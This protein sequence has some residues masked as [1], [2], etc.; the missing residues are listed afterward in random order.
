M[1]LLRFVVLSIAVSIVVPGLSGLP[2]VHGQTT[3]GSILG[4]VTD[5]SGAAVPGA[6]V[7]VVNDSNGAERETVAGPAGGFRI[8]VLQPSTYSVTVVA[9]GFSPVTRRGVVLP[10]QGEVKVDFVLQV[11]GAAEQILVNAD[12]PLIRPTENALR[13][14]VNNRSIEALPLLTR[15][16]MDLAVLAPGVTLDQSSLFN[17][18]ATDSISFF[19]LEESHKTLWLEGVDFGDEVTT[20]GT[21]TSSASRSPLPLDAIQEFDVMT[22]GYSPEFGRSQGGAVN[23]VLKSGGSELHGSVYSFFQDDAFNRTPWTISSGV[24]VKSTSE[25]SLERRSYGGTIGGPLSFLPSPAFYFFALDRFTDE[26]SVLITIPTDVE[27]FVEGLGLGY[28]TDTLVPLTRDRIVGVGKLTFDLARDHRLDLTYL[29]SDDDDLNKGVGNSTNVGGI[30]AADFGFDERDSS[31]FASANLTSV[32]G[33]RT[34]NEFRANRSIQRLIRTIPEGSGILPTL[35]FP[36]VVFGTNGID[37]FPSARVQKN[38]ILAN[39]TSYQWDNHTLRWGGEANLITANNEENLSFN[40]RYLFDTDTGPFDP[41]TYTARRNLQFERGE[42]SNVLAAG[43]DRDIDEY[44]LFVN[45][46]WRLG[47]G[48]TVNFGLRWDLRLLQGDF[49]RDDPFE[50]PGFSRDD[51]GPVWLAVALGP[52]GSLPVMA[53]RPVPRDKVDLSPRVGFAW[54]VSRTGRTVVRGSYGVFHDRFQT[55]R[56]DNTVNGYPGLNAQTF[57]VADPAFFPTVPDAS[58]FPAGAASTSNVPSPNATTPYSQHMS[59]GFQHELL[60]DLAL[61]VDFTHILLLHQVMRRNV[62]APDTGGVCPFAA[63]LTGAGLSPCFRMMMTHDTS[64]RGQV[65]SITFRLDRR[66]SD[67]VG[68]VVGYTLSGAKQFDRPGFFGI[69]PTDPNDLYRKIDYGPMDNDVPHR[70]TI[71]AFGELPWDISVSTIVTASS[72][73]PYNHRVGFPDVNNDGF[74]QDRPVGV[75]F[76]S[77]RGEPYFNTDLRVAKKVFFDDVKNIEVLFEMFNLFDTANRVNFNGAQN[78]GAFMRAQNVLAP[79]RS[80]LGV[81]FGF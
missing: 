13:T 51:P 53:W 73:P 28:N 47:P 76:N 23:V 59:G 44:A 63:E 33:P 57:E 15:D 74:F 60:D 79:F 32:L 52:A 66:F 69:E 48:L 43:L 36:S 35:E 4:D 75:G 46:T 50:Q 6:S 81:R 55:A 30:A 65:N 56:L 58:T 62:N 29:Y 12:A 18:A 80:Q 1:R 77:L 42:S 78:A 61:S 54:D 19:G 49:G 21:N 37:G 8:S 11:A 3:T 5:S 40:G 16:F 14:V 71:N 24:A 38:F 67:F 17:S 45:D 22:T 39:S 64:G 27:T 25:P 41:V 9:G 68:F 31:Y 2:R 26:D 34:V 20:G 7:T 70:L 72:A 10:I